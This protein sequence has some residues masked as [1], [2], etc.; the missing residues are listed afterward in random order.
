MRVLT[1]SREVYGGSQ[2]KDFVYW[3]SLAKP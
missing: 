2:G 1:Y 3:W